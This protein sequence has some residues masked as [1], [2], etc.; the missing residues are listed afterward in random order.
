MLAYN[1]GHFV[2]TLSWA[3]A[4]HRP[5]ARYGRKVPILAATGNWRQ[6]KNNTIEA[7]MLLKALSGCRNEAKK[8][9]KQKELYENIGNEAKKWLK[10]NNISLFSRADY[11]RFACD[12]AQIAR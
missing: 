6:N 10:T 5:G 3:D 9:L 12:L 11:V 1:C 8:Y 2:D 4:G 7:S